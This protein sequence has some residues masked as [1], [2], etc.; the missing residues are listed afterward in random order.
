M[1]A[2]ELMSGRV[3]IPSIEEM[4]ARR[5]AKKA[6][7]KEKVDVPIEKN[8]SQQL[9]GAEEVDIGAS[10]MS[11]GGSQVKKRKALCD[12][13]EDLENVIVKIPRGAAVIADPSSLSSF[14]DGL[15]LEEDEMRL[16]DLGSVEASRKAVALNY[17]VS[18]PRCIFVFSRFFFFYLVFFVVGFGVQHLSTKVD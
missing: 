1:C 5:K 2:A 11:A 8:E 6:R 3:K 9:L 17:Q 16:R 18:S 10:P 7:G 15:L 14:V 4:K 13:G 12:P